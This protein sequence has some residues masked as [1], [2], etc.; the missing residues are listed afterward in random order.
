MEMPNR[1][2]FVY[3][4]GGYYWPEQGI[5]GLTDEIKKYLDL[6]LFCC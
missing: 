5:V 3:A 4:A 2:V 6:R 1:D